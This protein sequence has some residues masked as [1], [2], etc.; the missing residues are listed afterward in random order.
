MFNTSSRLSLRCLQ[1]CETEKTL[2]I[3]IRT[4]KQQQKALF[5]SVTGVTVRLES[6]LVHKLYC[7]DFFWH[8]TFWMLPCMVVVLVDLYLGGQ[9]SLGSTLF[10]STSN[11]WPPESSQFLCDY[12]TTV[13]IPTKK[14][15]KIC[16][17]ILN[18]N[19]LTRSFPHFEC[20]STKHLL[21]F[22]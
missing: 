9:F 16:F 5:T 21:F 6:L 8:F 22:I 2:L 12:M 7:L 13:C 19:L 11:V 17:S 20:E 4:T 15:T 3:D 1:A 18:V 10:E 14:E